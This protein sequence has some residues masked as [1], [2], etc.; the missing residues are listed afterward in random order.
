M[1]HQL[2]HHQH[3][4]TCE[5]MGQFK[6]FYIKF[7]QSD[8]DNSQHKNFIYSKDELPTMMS[9]WEPNI[10]AALEEIK[11]VS[12]SL[13]SDTP[14]QIFRKI[15][16]DIH[17][18]M[19]KSYPPG[20]KWNAVKKAIIA[21]NGLKEETVDFLIKYWNMFSAF[22]NGKANPVEDFLPN[23]WRKP[24]ARNDKKS[25]GRESID[26]K[27]RN[28]EKSVEKSV[29]KKIED[30]FDHIAY[31]DKLTEWVKK[32]LNHGC[33]LELI[34]STYKKQKPNTPIYKIYIDAA[35]TAALFKLTEWANKEL[36]VGS[37]IEAIKNAILV[38]YK[39]NMVDAV[40]EELKKQN[41]LN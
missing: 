38:R 22:N 21:E 11:E 2:L 7:E 40:M 41:K 35:I 9:G 29:E 4:Q 16:F 23:W 18:K 8:V 15:I 32:E 5:F 25:G 3:R 1:V 27:S 30:D 6:N 28:V 39:Q 13:T 20:E 17:E 10:A 31:I 24:I 14:E 33:S 37:S 19:K 12:V 36:Q 26:D 34:R